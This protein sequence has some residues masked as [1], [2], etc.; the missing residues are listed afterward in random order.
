MTLNLKLAVKV[1]LISKLSSFYLFIACMLFSF[2]YLG[3]NNDHHNYSHDTGIDPSACSIKRE[4]AND[5]IPAI[6]YPPSLSH[7]LSLPLFLYPSLLVLSG[8]YLCLFP[9]LFTPSISLY[10]PLIQNARL[11][12]RRKLQNTIRCGHEWCE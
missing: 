1:S 8:L 4:A 2:F 10:L 9:P 6:K 12:R 3:T 11:L 7:P 5:I